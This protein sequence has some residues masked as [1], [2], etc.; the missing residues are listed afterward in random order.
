MDRQRIV[1]DW[2]PVQPQRRP[3][4]A[5]RALEWLGGAVIAVGGL[6]LKFGAVFV[7][8]G[9]LFVSVGA[10]ALLGGWQWGIGIV[11]LIFVHEMGHWLE[12]K[13]Q[14][15]RVSAPMFIPFIGAYVTIK[16]AGLTP[17]RSATIA[18]A[19]PFLGGVGAAVCWW[20]GKSQGSHLFTTLGYTGFLLN[21][22]NLIPIGFLDGGAIA[23]AMGEAWRMPVIHFEGGVPMRALEPDRSRAV[24]IATLYVGVAVLLIY[25]MTRT[26]VP[27]H[28]L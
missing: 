22:F 3:G 4:A 25:G 24:L 21:L 11:A 10:Y 15:L 26:H 18:L 7:K 16:H 8:F 17:W 20:I 28:R 2:E 6:A 9:A 19:G 14:G 13:R 23:R 5:R 1:T 12:A 27:Q